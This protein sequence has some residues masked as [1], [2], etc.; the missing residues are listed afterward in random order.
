M[1][2]SLRGVDMHGANLSGAD[3]QAS[4]LRRA[5]FTGADLSG[6][7]LEDADLTEAKLV[8][9]DLTGATLKQSNLTGT[10]M[11]GATLVMSQLKAARL[12]GTTMPDGTDDSSGCMLP[13]ATPTPTE[14]SSPSTAVSITKFMA[15]A[16]VVCPSS[17]PSAVVTVKIKYA[18]VNATSVEFTI[19]GQSP[20]AG[21]GYNPSNGTASLSFPCNKS[22]HK[23]TIIASP[24]K[25]SS[26]KQSKVVYR[27]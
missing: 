22:S 25:G 18:T 7:N 5:D 9:A 19:D 24:D 11:T 15:P 2:S 23:Y 27:T 3:L 13:T 26:Q 1:S 4:D 21:A 12:C 6:A 10:D 17:P 14:S 20:G 8:G 16:S